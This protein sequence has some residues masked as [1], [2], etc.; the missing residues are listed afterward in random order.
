MAASAVSLK[1]LTKLEEVRKGADQANYIPIIQ[2]LFLDSWRRK[3]FKN[4]WQ[5]NEDTLPKN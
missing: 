3:N 1:I 2:L 4:K 5:Y